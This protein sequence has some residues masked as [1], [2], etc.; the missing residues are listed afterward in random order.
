MNMNEE[1]FRQL[2][3]ISSDLIWTCKG[4]EEQFRMTYIN[5]A[6]YD[7]L[8]YTPE[9]F[10]QLPIE[11]RMT[12]SSLKNV[13]KF[14]KQLYES[15]EP[16]VFEI[17]HIRKDGGLVDFEL[18]VKPI[19]N[20][21]G[22]IE[23]LYGRSINVTEYKKALRELSVTQKLFES[24]IDQSPVP[25]VLATPDGR[26]QVFN[27]A[28][29]EQL[30]MQDVEFSDKLT[31]MNQT[32]KDYDSDGNLL[33]VTD[34]P[35]YKALEGEV[36]KNLE[37]KVV[38]HD[39]TVRWEIVNGAPIYDD[40]GNLI[41]GFV[42]FPDITTQKLAKEELQRHKDNLEEMVARRTEELAHAKDAAEDASRAKSEFLANISHE[43]RT[44]LNAILGYSQMLLKG[45]SLSDIQN[46]R[47]KII[48]RSGEHLLELING[49]LSIS[50]IEARH[51]T[52]EKEAF[53]LNEMMAAI[54][55]MFRY[56]A[57]AKGLYLKAQ[58]DVSDP[59]YIYGDIKKIRQI[60][61]NLIGNAIK[62][63][64]E[65]GITMSYHLSES[66][67]I[68]D[69]DNNR[70]KFRLHLEIMDTG[71]GISEGD[72]E[73]LFEPFMQTAIGK[74]H[75]GTGLGLTISRNYAR[76]MAGDLTLAS[77]VGTGSTFV[78][79]IE[80][81]EADISELRT[82][83]EQRHVVGIKGQHIPTILVAEDSEESKGL[84]VSML[85]DV[86]FLVESV[87]NGQK[88]V[89]YVSEKVPD[90]I[91]MD[92]KMPVMDGLEAT[93]CIRNMALPK[94]VIITALTASAM[95]EE[96]EQIADAGCDAIMHKP[97]RAKDIYMVIG[98]LLNIDYIYEDDASQANM[99][100]PNLSRPKSMKPVEM[101][102]LKSM[103]FELRNEL[104]DVALRLNVDETM[105]VIHKI[106]K[107][108]PEIGQY[109]TILVEHYEFERILD[110]LEEKHED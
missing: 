53:D 12:E 41:A 15:N 40:D 35:L 80:V 29:R 32:W 6:A 67:G 30:L 27:D 84:I 86:G 89:D 21:E 74:E 110:L 109:L 69:D 91:F 102:G 66:E 73:Q 50:K 104:Y 45:N 46:E 22:K 78:V 51:I 96:Q 82:D 65:G 1:Q 95:D 38:R 28:C 98:E 4:P 72:Q 101:D 2:T 60:L 52:L 17:T 76:L 88:A 97:F 79:D 99:N 77:S 90:F 81:E 39:G 59:C 47:I 94:H 25:I 7:L 56:N 18:L 107:D 5:S 57:E 37:V 87:V 26:L 48:N 23:D 11:K 34:L 31:E 19:F 70:R 33:D 36:T 103:S 85:E 44:P 64:E 106:E 14:I 92:V 8:G 105:K 54:S 13:D 55:D 42:A 16:Q 20:D 61:I 108:L 49:V 83:K 10:L 63:T 58:A 43:L 3:E 9:E 93:R 100:Q 24:V 68:T 75:K 62:F 71:Y